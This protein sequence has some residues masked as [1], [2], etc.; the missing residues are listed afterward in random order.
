MKDDLYME[1]SQ[2]FS[3]HDDHNDMSTMYGESVKSGHSGGHPP[4]VASL[5]SGLAQQAKTLVNTM[6]NFNCAGFNERNGSAMYGGDGGDADGDMPY[7][8]N[9][10]ASARKHRTPVGSSSSR[11][12]G[13]SASAG[14]NSKAGSRSFRQY[15]KSPQR[16]DI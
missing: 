2:S 10:S 14:R 16:I 11:Q 12:R 5:G 4:S 9:R 1:Q 15:S 6:N 8:A 3:S 13:R 7:D